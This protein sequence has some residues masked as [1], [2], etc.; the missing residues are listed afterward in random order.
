[1]KRALFYLLLVAIPLMAK[2]QLP[3]SLQRKYDTTKT[4]T[5]KAIIFDYYISKVVKGTSADKLKSL[6]PYLSY[7]T[8]TRDDAGVACVQ[9]EISFLCSENG[10]VSISL[11]YALAALP[12]FEKLKDTLQLINV[13]TIIGNSLRGSGN[14]EQAI[15]YWRKLYPIARNFNLASYSTVLNNM[16]DNY[17][18]MNLPDSAL[19]YIQEAVSIDRKSKDTISLAFSLGTLGETYIAI[20]DYEIAKALIKESISFAKKNQL[21]QVLDYS[22]SD[23]AQ[24]FF[25]TSKFD[26]SLNYARQALHYAYPY[27]LLD[28]VRAYEL[29]YKS[30]DKLNKQ[31][32]SNKYFR[33]AMEVKD[34]ILSDQKNKNIQSMNFQEQIR[35]QEIEIQLQE[36]ATQH[37]QNIENV[38]IALG[39]I[40][41]I[42]LFLLLSRQFITNVKVIRFLGIAALLLVFEFI[43]LLVHT[44][45]E[46][47]TNHSQILML[48]LLVCIAALLIP[49]HHKLEHWAI[50][51]M[52]EKNKAVRLSAAKRTIEKLEVKVK[53]PGE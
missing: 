23:M 49:L 34:S 25:E 7:F 4:F 31:D 41:F 3:D 18:T 22:L 50:N 36:V 44:Y 38:L 1:M 47:K 9:L 48:L 14:H 24:I 8:K 39:I 16:A 17:N 15:V 28:A 45:I 33:M 11:K 6:F 42:M 46:E 10:D 51:K 27:Y 40:S 13:Y 12:Y 5:G 32:S 2:S 20:K 43:N 26:S 35:Q 30:F 21:N 37:K 19:P 53:S 29:M 52:I